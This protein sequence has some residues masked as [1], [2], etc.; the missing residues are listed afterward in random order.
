M[1]RMV[2]R[3]G[4]IAPYLGAALGLI[5]LLAAFGTMKYADSAEDAAE[6]SVDHARQVSGSAQAVL[7][8]VLQAET[9]Q[10]AYLLTGVDSHLE[11]YR[12]EMARVPS[13]VRHL[14]RVTQGEDEHRERVVQI[15]RLVDQKLST[16]TSAVALRGE[17]GLQAAAE[18]VETGAGISVMN[19]LRVSV[20]Q[21]QL[22]ADRAAQ[23]E[24]RR[25][26]AASQRASFV[27]DRAAVMLVGLLF[28]MIALLVRRGQMQR[29][30]RSL[31][32]ER[33]DL[34]A[35]LGRLT[36][37]DPLTGLPNRR[38]LEDRIDHAVT[39]S[40]RD[41]TPVGLVF[42][43]LD[44]FH[45]VNRSFGRSSGDHLLVE[46]AQRLSQELRATDT[47][48]RVG[49]DQFVA[50]CEGVD[51]EA[52]LLA[53]AHRLQ[54][55][56]DGAAVPGGTEE[57]TTTVSVGLV[58]AD[59]DGIRGEGPA[60]VT[61]AAMLAAGETA[62][63]QAKDSGGGCIR[64]YDAEGA[65]SSS[66][67]Q[68]LRADLRNAIAAGDQIWVAYQPL[69][70][71]DTEQVVGA[72][73]LLRWNHPTRGPISPAEFVPLAEE[74][75]QIVTL[76]EQ[77]LREACGQA[78]AWNRRRSLRGLPPLKMSINVSARQLLIPG[79]AHSV[80]AILGATRLDAH[81]LTLE[82]TETALVDGAQGA[83]RQLQEL[84]DHGVTV[85]LDDF[86]TGYSSLSYLRQFPIGLIKIDR[87]FI[88]GLG[89]TPADEAIVRSVIALGANL[90]RPVLAEGIETEAQ[91]R[92]LRDWGCRYGQGFHYGRPTTAATADAFIPA[93]VL[94]GV[95]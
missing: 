19:D 22:A 64:W 52:D 35:E 8:S 82:I 59:H 27:G 25:A 62:M 43:D 44:Q 21:L 50:L 7:H 70:D 3:L 34:A 87:S 95:Y 93:A 10:R 55:A 80:K 47:L 36:T 72:E 46:I 83:T 17:Q 81:A 74:T 14:E 40:A 29:R 26:E 37:K 65:R 16:L 38:L 89:R 51:S 79:F 12:L 54:R 39:R 33:L 86:G 85:G 61:A 5:L 88:Q 24:T 11:I 57:I 69:V 1:A 42:L 68:Q 4:G 30:H 92:R 90:D 63:S 23:V 32:L 48:A 18:Q 91:A 60:V 28:V 6:A 84:A 2:R 66:G 78:A 73:A 76:G 75:G 56:V 13:Q 20:G 94:A 49:P 53:T 9:S 15:R 58:I 77:V 41:R 67:R 31:E 45:H 71:L